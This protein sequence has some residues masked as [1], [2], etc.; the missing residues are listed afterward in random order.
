MGFSGCSFRNTVAITSYKMS[1]G[2]ADLRQRRKQNCTE[3][4]KMA[5]EE[6]H[7][8]NSKLGRSPKCKLQNF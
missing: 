6:R 4:D 7:K 5:P 2:A 3:S 1:S 8:E